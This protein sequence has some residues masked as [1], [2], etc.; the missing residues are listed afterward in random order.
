MISP[1][2]EKR[3]LDLMQYLV[4]NSC[5]ATVKH[6]YALVMFLAGLLAK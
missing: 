5:V 4:E 2:T 1:T 6:D 3:I